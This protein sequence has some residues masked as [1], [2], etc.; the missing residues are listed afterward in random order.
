MS[1]QAEE[2]ACDFGT[3]ALQVEGQAAAVAAAVEAVVAV[4]AMVAAAG[5]AAGQECAS[6]CDAIYAFHVCPALDSLQ[7]GL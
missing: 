2:E 4:A 3:S 5:Q 1:A 7:L 6:N